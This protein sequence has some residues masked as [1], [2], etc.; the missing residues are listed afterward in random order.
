M[1]NEW[2]RSDFIYYSIL[3]SYDEIAFI[4]HRRNF[5]FP[6]E[7]WQSVFKC[8]KKKKKKEKRG[9]LDFLNIGKPSPIEK[10]AKHNL[11]LVPDENNFN[12]C[13]SGISTR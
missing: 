10:L 13:T 12:E 2:V 1:Y 9:S 11:V 4:E 3:F 6:I 5:V 7:T 8:R